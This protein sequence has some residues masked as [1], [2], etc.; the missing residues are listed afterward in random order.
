ME[1]RLVTK[2]AEEELFELIVRHASKNRFTVSNILKVV[3]KVVKY[4]KNNAVIEVEDCIFVKRNS[5]L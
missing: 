2:N 3:D 5:P 4:M 1:K